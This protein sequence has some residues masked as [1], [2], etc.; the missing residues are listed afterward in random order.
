MPEVKKEVKKEVKTEKSEKEEP[1]AD[2]DDDDG[3]C[4]LT[5]KYLRYTVSIYLFAK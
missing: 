2:V 4:K 3:T 5:T 1:E